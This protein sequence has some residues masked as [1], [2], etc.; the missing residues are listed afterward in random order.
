[1]RWI[2]VALVMMLPSKAWAEASAMM[3]LFKPLNLRFNMISKNGQ[4]MI[5]WES[6]AFQVVDADFKEPYLTIK[7]YGTTATFKAIVDVSQMKGYGGISQ[8]DGKKT[9]GEIICAFD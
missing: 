9:E 4:D 7:Q 2:A 1:M 3:C 8:F 6:N 5:Q